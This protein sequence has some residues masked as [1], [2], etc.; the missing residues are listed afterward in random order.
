[1]QKERP[2]QV[3]VDKLLGKTTQIEEIKETLVI[4]TR[5]SVIAANYCIGI[6]FPTT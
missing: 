5:L 2:A 6:I 1:V 4:T 3:N